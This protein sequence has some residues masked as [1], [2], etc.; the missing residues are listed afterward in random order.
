MNTTITKFT[1]KQ[2]NK[3][4]TI[5][6]INGVWIKGNHFPSAR[7]NMI[8]RKKLPSRGFILNVLKNSR[9][10]ELENR[11]RNCPTFMT[12]LIPNS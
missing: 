6:K 10:F 9:P 2:L 11:S 3:K 4:I 12:L 7:A 5:M 8:I 1:N